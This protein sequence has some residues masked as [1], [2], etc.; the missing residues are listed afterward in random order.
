MTYALEA[1]VTIAKMVSLGVL[2]GLVGIRCMNPADPFLGALNVG[3]QGGAPAPTYFGLASD[4]EPS[5][6]GF[7]DWARDEL[8]DLVFKAANDL[9]VPTTGV[10][11]RNGAPGFPIPAANRL[12]FRP[13]D[14]ISHSDY[15]PSEQVRRRI[16]AWLAP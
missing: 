4:F 15:L 16:A 14:A 3:D 9:M 12:V 10:Y 5:H 2:K 13:Q 1:L 7:R 11:E 8:V 6:G